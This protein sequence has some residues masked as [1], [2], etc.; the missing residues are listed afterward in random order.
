MIS[1]QPFGDLVAVVPSDTLKLTVNF[2]PTGS[3]KEYLIDAKNQRGLY[4][5]ADGNLKIMSSNGNDETLAVTAGT[6]L[7]MMVKRVYATGTTATVYAAID[8]IGQVP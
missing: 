5:T 8:G 7:E 3:K 2:G 1:K 6:Y 4:I